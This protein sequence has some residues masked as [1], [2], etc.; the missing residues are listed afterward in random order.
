MQY[1]L[2]KLLLSALCFM[3]SFTTM[4]ATCIADFDVE[5]TT[6]Y[7]IVTSTSNPFWTDV[8]EWS[9]DG[10]TVSGEFEGVTL[11]LPTENGIYQVCFY[12]EDTSFGCSDE[13]CM[14]VYV[15]PASEL[16][17]YTD[18][19]WP[20]DAN[21]DGK[22]NMYD[23]LNIGYGFYSSGP[24]REGA[25]TEWQGQLATDWGYTTP[26]GV[27]FKHMDVNGDGWIDELDAELVTENY[28]P[29]LDLIGTAPSNAPKVHI[30]FDEESM[31]FDDNSPE[32][33]EITAT[34]NLD[35]LEGLEIQS[36]AFTLN[37]PFDL[38]LPH[39]V[40]LNTDDE[41]TIFGA[42]NVGII[43]VHRDLSVNGLGRYDFAVSS[44]SGLSIPDLSTITTTRF[45]VIGDII[46]GRTETEIDFPALIH[47][48]RAMTTDG[49]EI[50]LGENE[51]PSIFTI[52]DQT[53]TS[54]AE[55][56]I[57]AEIGLY[58]NPVT[59]NIMLDLGEH[60]ADAASVYN[61]TGQLVNTINVN[62]RYVTGETKDLTAGIY[63]VKIQTNKGLAIKRFV[64]Q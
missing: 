59:D 15:G 20:G 4:Q 3:L 13:M 26:A 45:I 53:T 1:K 51:A 49:E 6:D 50:M 18:C 52:I 29:V 5:V 38:V 61:A 57:S 43:E 41:A 48:V 11:P 54:T 35:D 10:V 27:D 21:G 22:A 40:E 30:D 8:H 9:F 7:I 37:Y 60:Q 63:F 16:C 64:K 14:D 2:Y 28:T 24:T 39:S 31:I 62:G 17:N 46:Q 33:M 23:L 36:L 55:A 32:E 42:G 34:I 25:T 58:P 56:G 47:S 12:V 19:V 44:I